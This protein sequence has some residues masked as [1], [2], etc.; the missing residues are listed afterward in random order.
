MGNMGLARLGQQT[1]L[2]DCIFRSKVPSPLCHVSI[3]NDEWIGP[4]ASEFSCATK[5]SQQIGKSVILQKST[6]Q[7]FRAEHNLKKT[8][9]LMYLVVRRRHIHHQ[10]ASV[11]GRLSNSS[12]SAF[13]Q[14]LLHCLPADTQ[15]FQQLDTPTVRFC[16]PNSNMLLTTEEIDSVLLKR[17]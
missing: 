17:T 9:T 7:T 8:Y 16:H 6:N 3:G 4:S 10:R 15:P 14:E 2:F 11:R 12:D 5:G 13:S 1:T